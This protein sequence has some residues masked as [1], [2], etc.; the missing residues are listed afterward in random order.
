MADMIFQRKY[1]LF[2]VTRSYGRGDTEHTQIKEVS[3]VSGHMQLRLDTAA[4]VRQSAWQNR[5]LKTHVL[6]IYVLTINANSVSGCT[7][8][9]S[10]EYLRV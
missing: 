2:G 3:H 1:F 4:G 10:L 6:Y 9:G 7:I 5:K 8:P